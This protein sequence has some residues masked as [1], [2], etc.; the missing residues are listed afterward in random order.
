[1]GLLQDHDATQTQ[2]IRKLCGSVGRLNHSTS[3]LDR[4]QTESVSR[5][6]RL[7]DPVTL[8]ASGTSLQITVF[9]KLIYFQ[10]NL[11]N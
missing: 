11:E 8:P 10:S 3:N 2:N 4:R 9:A 5:C 7:P 1:M 6:R